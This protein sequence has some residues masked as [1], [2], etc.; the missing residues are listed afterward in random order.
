[1]VLVISCISILYCIQLTNPPEKQLLRKLK[2]HLDLF[3]NR[4]HKTY[5]TNP[6]VKRL[7]QRYQHTKM[8][9]SKK[10]ETFTLN[11]G[12]KIVM[13]LKDYSQN[14]KIHDD[15]NLL[16][17]VGIHELAHIMS[18][19]VNHTTEFWNNFK[20]LLEN[21]VYWNMYEPIDYSYD[22]AQYCNMLVYDN[23]Y[24]YERSFKDFAS[25][26]TNIISPNT[27]HH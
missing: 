3:V 9:E 10:P 23:P 15:F 25:N 18:I 26:L 13:C 12:E 21:A 11:K 5:P 16:V 22:P 2:K 6:N 8:F 4:L 20:F 24:F 14:K 17:F 27:H 7:V 19:T 1:M